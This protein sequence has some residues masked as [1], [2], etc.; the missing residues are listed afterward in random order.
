MG[1]FTK[2]NVEKFVAQNATTWG[3]EC[4]AVRMTWG[5]R[6]LLRAEVVALTLRSNASEM[7]HQD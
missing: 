1:H 5:Y 4:M 7:A 6:R 2:A 3:T